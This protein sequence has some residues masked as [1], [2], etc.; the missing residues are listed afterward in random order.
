M[1]IEL[2]LPVLGHSPKILKFYA[3]TDFEHE[4]HKAGLGVPLIG[5]S[6]FNW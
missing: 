5:N 6:K 2:R 1:V 3:P 4:F